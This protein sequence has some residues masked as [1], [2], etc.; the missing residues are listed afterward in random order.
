MKRTVPKKEETMD[1]QTNN[2]LNNLIKIDFKSQS[3]SGNFD[4]TTEIIDVKKIAQEIINPEESAFEIYNEFSKIESLVKS[5]RTAI[6]K[7]VKFLREKKE[8]KALSRIIEYLGQKTQLQKKDEDE[9]LQLILIDPENPKYKKAK[10]VIA[11]DCAP[12]INKKIK[13]KIILEGKDSE[14]ILFCPQKKNVEKLYINKLSKLFAK[15]DI[16]SVTIIQTQN[17]CCLNM[18]KIVRQ[19]LKNLNKLIPNKE[20]TVLLNV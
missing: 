10:L 12:F 16:Q 15:N 7:R 8:K 5:G 14:L 13:E 11:A 4:K 19:V 1:N 20:I 18:T 9:P 17:L 3:N 6:R 2:D